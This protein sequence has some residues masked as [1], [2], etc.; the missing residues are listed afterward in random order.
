MNTQPQFTDYRGEPIKLTKK[1]ALTFQRRQRHAAVLTA[2]ILLIAFGAV[3]AVTQIDLTANVKGILPIANG[4]TNTSSTL[5]GV[6]RG[7]SSYTASELSGDVTTSGSN[8]ATVAKINGSS[9]TTNAAADQTI[10]STASA[11]LAYKTIPD[12]PTGALEYAQSTHAFSCGTVLTGTF[13]DAEVPSGT[14][15]GSTTAFTLAHTPSPA[16]SLA[17]YENG[18]EERAAGADY[19]LATA[20]I[21]YGVA[22]P[23]GTTLVCYYRY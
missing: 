5:T 12:C 22:P 21:T 20:T 17:C 1:R 4:G 8:A 13:A 18:V 9:I 11:T 16:A 10:I 6:V 23:T 3:A 2:A 19:T 7:G 15:N 14:I